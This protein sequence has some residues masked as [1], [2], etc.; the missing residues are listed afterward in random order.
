MVIGEVGR[1]HGVRGALRV[2]PTGATLATR[3]AGD[4]VTL[5]TPD[6]RR[7]DRVIDAIHPHGDSLTLQLEGVADRTAADGLRGALIVVP[8]AGLPGLPDGEFYVRD[9][10]GCA[11]RVD[12]RPAGTVADV[13]PGAANDV[14]DVRR[15]DGTSLLVPFTRDA[16]AAVDVAGGVIDVRGGLLDEAGG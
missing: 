6:G 5:V 4:A 16:L 15:D 2:R 8:A 14:L 1:A 12:G 13:L 9:M 3:A 10:I 7:V 11:V